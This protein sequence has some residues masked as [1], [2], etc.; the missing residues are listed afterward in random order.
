MPAEPFQLF[1]PRESKVE[2][3]LTDGLRQM[4]VL[5]TKPKSKDWPDQL[6]FWFNG[7]VDTAEVKKPKGGVFT[8]GQ[9]R[10]HEKLRQRGHNV[11]LLFTEA[12]VDAYLASREEYGRAIGVRI[13]PVDK[14]EQATNRPQ[15]SKPKKRAA[16]G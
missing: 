3:R 7:I 9:L 8:V 1:R 6:M 13:E 11:Y 5:H 10:M 12:E 4:R 15:K 16:T 14:Y 2:K